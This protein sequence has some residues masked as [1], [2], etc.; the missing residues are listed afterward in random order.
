M[1]WLIQKICGKQQKLSTVSVPCPQ[2]NG[3]RN[4]TIHCGKL[5]NGPKKSM[6]R[7]ANGRAIRT[8]VLQTRI[9]IMDKLARQ[10][11]SESTILLFLLLL[12]PAAGF[13]QSTLIFPKFFSPEELPNSGFAI[14]N[15]GPAA[16]SVTFT[17]Y[18][19]T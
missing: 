5:K 9:H 11:Y 3:T 19:T 12:L 1:I 7:L 8:R 4:W 13:G 15:P 16:A 17:L 6:A 2:F 10:G 14:V 18:S